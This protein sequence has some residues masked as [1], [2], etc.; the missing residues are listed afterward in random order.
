MQAFLYLTK[1][2]NTLSGTVSPDLRILVKRGNF[3]Y[4]S[5]LVAGLPMTTNLSKPPDVLVKQ[6]SSEG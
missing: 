2:I 3:T 4:P 1:E 6:S 5:L